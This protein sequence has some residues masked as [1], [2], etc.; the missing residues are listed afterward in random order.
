[1]PKSKFCQYRTISVILETGAMISLQDEDSDEIFQINP[2]LLTGSW[3]DGRACDSGIRPTT[4]CHRST[5]RYRTSSQRNSSFII[6]QS[7]FLKFF[8]E[9]LKKI[10]EDDI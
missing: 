1:M 6:H 3:R 10:G 8:F 9:K 2:P 5:D 4:S 7:H